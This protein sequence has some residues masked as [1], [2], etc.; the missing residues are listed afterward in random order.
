MAAWRTITRYLPSLILAFILAVAVWITA[1][2]ASDPVE[3][4]VYPTPVP[5]EII[6][7]DPGLVITSDTPAPVTVTLSAPRS[8]WDNSTSQPI[9]IR[10]L[11]DLSGLKAGKFDVAIQIDVG[12]RLAE[13]VSYTPR[14]FTITL[15]LLETRNL[16]IQVNR[17]G[18]PAVGFQADPPTL[19]Q[20]TVAV[21]GP[22]SVVDRVNQVLIDDDL[23]GATE[24][25]NRLIA[26]QPVDANQN[27]VTGVTL[28]PDK[29]TLSQ[30]I[31]QRGGYR[32]VV[33]KVI[34]AGTVATGYRLTNITVSPPAVTVFSSNPQLVAD[35]PGYIETTMLNL[36]NI[37]QDYDTRLSIN[38]PSGISVVGDSTVLVQVG[39]AA[40]QGSL[41]FTNNTVEIDGLP[42]GMIASI[43]P[44][45]VDV[46]L[47]GPLPLLDTLRS[48][49][50]RVYVD[51]SNV[52]KVGNYQRAP[53]VEI[54]VSDLSVESILPE[55]VE[56]TVTVAP[57]PTPTVTPTLFR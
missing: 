4:R 21:S 44:E 17:H 26:L 31:A 5:V 52:T 39:V 32:N 6:G 34:V 22:K 10:A 55:S 24:S 2:T 23:T 40:I 37:K 1:V 25:S 56:V 29:V 51:L 9:V 8:I 48:E 11:A 3:E 33:V 15:E 47:S 13:V 57:T 53:Q 12:T 18:E 20:A 16:V 42:D 19:S 46:I 38:L 7:Q 35:L 45:T 28:S 41:T 49:N 14:S 50:L 54:R 36:N 30:S 43:S 27:T